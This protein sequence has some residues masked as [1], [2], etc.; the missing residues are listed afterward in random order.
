MKSVI[1]ILKKLTLNDA[2]L[3]EMINE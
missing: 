3:V 2:V 1:T